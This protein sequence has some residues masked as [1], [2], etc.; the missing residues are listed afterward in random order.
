MHGQ[1]SKGEAVFPICL[2]AQWVTRSEYGSYG[3]QQHRV[4]F[5]APHKITLVQRI[6]DKYPEVYNAYMASSHRIWNT[7]YTDGVGIQDES[8]DGGGFRIFLDYVEYIHPI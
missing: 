7:D 5:K 8:T 1:R 2:W 4:I 3:F 6:F